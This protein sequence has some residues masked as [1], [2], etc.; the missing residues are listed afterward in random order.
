MDEKE[1]ENSVEQ[2]LNAYLPRQGPSPLQTT[3]WEFPKIRGTLLGVP[4]IRTLVFWGLYW[5]PLLL[6]DYQIL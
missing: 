4:I 2:A 6:G 5:G 1:L 3:K